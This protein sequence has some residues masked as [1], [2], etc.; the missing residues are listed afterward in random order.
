MQR[1]SS[2]FKI[3]LGLIALL[4]FQLPVCGQLTSGNL[5]GTVYDPAGATVPGATVTA[6]NDAT[7]VDTSTTSTSAGAYRFDNL[8]IGTYT[9]NV[10]ATGF[11]NAQ[12]RNITIALNQTVTNNVQLTIGQAATTVEVS[13]AFVQIDTTTAQVQTTYNA[14][15]LAD[16]PSASGGQAGSGVINLSLLNAGVTSTGGAGY[17][18]GP[19]VGGQ[20]PTN[21]N[22]TIE[23]IDNN[24]LAVTGPVVT[25]P[26][27]AVSEFSVLQNQ[28][29]PDFGHS[30]GGQFN[31]VVKSGTNQ[32]HGMAY[33]YFQNRNLNAADNLASVQGTP[34]HPRFDENRFGGNF[35]GPIIRNK[36]FFFVD[37]E[38][39]PFGGTNSTSYYAPIG[40]SYSVL[41]KIAG[42]NPNNLAQFEKYLGTATTAV[43]DSTLP[44]GSAVQIATAPGSNK[45]LGTGVFAGNASGAGIIN[46]PVG[47]VS[48]SLP[49]YQNTEFGVASVDYNISDKDSLRGRFILE[50]Q[51]T[52]D[53]TGF[54]SV[55]FGVQPTNSYLVTVSEY[56]TFSPTLLNEFRFGYNRY[57][58]Q[59]PVFGNQS[60]PGL[61]AFP[62]I[63]VD[64]LN[65]AYGPDPNA[66][67]FTIQNLYQLTDNVT[68]TKGSHSFKFGFDGWSAISPS[69]FT[70]RSRGDY[71]WSYL[72]DYLFDNNPDVLAE[73]GIGHVINYQNQQLLGAYANDN[74]K[75]RP[76]LTVNLGVRYEYLTIPLTQNEQDLN[77]SAS[78]PGLIEFKSPTAQKA[79]FMPRVGAA[80]SPGNSGK[81]SIR[82][83]FGL[84]YDILY[85]N[86]GGTTL[87]PQLNSTVDVGGVDATGFLAG[88][89]IPGNTSVAVPEGAAA[90][91]VTSG[92][93]PNQQRPA[94]YNWNFGIQHEFGGNY[95]FET[96][97]L[98]T[99]GLFLP[100]QMRLNIQPVVNSSNA[101]PVY[102]TMPSQATLNS[103]GSTLGNLQNAF[104]NNGNIIP[105]YA[106]AGF[107]APITA[108]MPQG[109]SSYNGWVTQLTRR[110]SNGL[111]FQGSYTWSHNIDDSTD[112]LNATVLAPRRP[113]DFQNLRPER[114]SSLL[115]YR[116]RIVLQVLYDVPFFK[117]RNWWLKNIVGNWEIAPVY[118]YQSGQH[119]TPQS[120]T[121]SN[122]NGDSAPDR[123]I[124]N[125]AGN[126]NLGTTANA[127]T[128]SAG[129]TVAY[130]AADPNAMFVLAPR[131]TLPTSGRSL[132][133]LNPIDNIDLTLLKRVAITER[134][135]LEFS[136]RFWNVLNHPQYTGGYLNDVAPFGPN[137]SGAGYAAGTAAGILAQK[138]IQ[139]GSSIF[140]QWSQAFSSNPRQIQLALKLI[141]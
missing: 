54:P 80:Y 79:I 14:K 66:P 90:R 44:F 122:M 112:A 37:Y 31:Q 73:R 9:L 127:L 93:I 15:Q 33:D 52:I 64:E 81:T 65:A 39:Q 55:F 95:I 124:I 61:D 102:F 84:T 40:S 59:F 121:D 96:R 43:P 51:G 2:I 11:K 32:F 105:A 48:S 89:G 107:L 25:V 50:R 77:A 78:V 109:N 131:G 17:G 87:P 83:G 46:L 27:D 67:Q 91:A 53:A 117:N 116:N 128:N 6:H 7:G 4:L 34:L 86:L 125:P 16:L 24:S 69:A 71:E 88:G 100:I 41:A 68:W 18:T 5:A 13:E 97:Y 94:A 99:R 58:Q 114:A 118:T 139:P 23:G 62:N 140:E 129:D 60:F 45:G 57:N 75:V 110:F 123:V 108:F 120:V 42:I 63:L 56:H 101:L 8:P 115:D 104:D 103:L 76:N 28:F 130:L 47:L 119:V 98:G 20:R 82:A 136:A 92:F 113:M 138:T 19:S 29:S 30:S 49:S 22:Y 21:N 137:G 35:G 10:T 126:R 132:L 38:Y 134:F 106:N 135:K 26:N 111:Q 141:F 85:D 36:L 1:N 70:Q 133:N 74:W 72:T 3:G 12:V